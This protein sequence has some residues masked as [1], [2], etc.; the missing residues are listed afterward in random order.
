VSSASGTWAGA[1]EDGRWVVG[2]PGR[3]VLWAGSLPGVIALLPLLERPMV[4]V[5]AE[6]GVA[7]LDGH[8]LGFEDVV[9]AALAGRASGYW[10]EQA[11]AWLDAGFPAD[12]YR[13][14]LRR[15]LSDKGIGQRSRQTAAR[16]LAR[17]LPGPVQPG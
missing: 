16:I 10:A 13:D 5:A 1:S 12:A 14:G 3:H 8:R 17:E 11:I 15:A 4:Q 6:L 9:G 7:S 2:R